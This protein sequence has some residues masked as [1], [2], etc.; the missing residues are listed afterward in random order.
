MYA[1]MADI[2]SATAEIRRGKKEERRTNDRMKNIWS[3][4][5]LLHKATINIMNVGGLILVVG[6]RTS[7]AVFLAFL[8]VEVNI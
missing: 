7:E 6:L 4:V 2:H 3:A 5:G 8:L 1:S